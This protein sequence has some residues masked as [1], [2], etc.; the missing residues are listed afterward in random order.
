MGEASLSSVSDY[1][2][3]KNST[4]NTIVRC[5]R[6]AEE[7]EGGRAIGERRYKEE[8]NEREGET[9]EKEERDGST[10]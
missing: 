2:H 10:N 9:R 1:C 8:N 7:R 4:G 6:H 5:F 3:W